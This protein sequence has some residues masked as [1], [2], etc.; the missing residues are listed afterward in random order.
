MYLDQLIERRKEL[1]E[2]IATAADQIAAIDREMVGMD[3]EFDLIQ[4]EKKALAEEVC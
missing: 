3:L 1:L 4:A 2:T